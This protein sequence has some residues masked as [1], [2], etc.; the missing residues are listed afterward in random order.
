MTQPP[1]DHEP[2]GFAQPGFG[3]PPESNPP[4]P[5]Y[6]TAPDQPYPPQPYGTAPDQPYP[7]QPYG[8]V[9]PAYGY[10]PQNHGGATTAMWL[11][12]VSLAC[13]A[14]AMACCVTVPGVLTAPFAWVLG[15][16]A[17][18]QIDAEPGRYANRGQAVA[19]IVTGIIGTV[20]A[21]LIVLGVVAVAVYYGLNWDDTTS[22]GNA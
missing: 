10:G 7:P 21:I 11:G 6:G 2:D 9:P 17:K 15:V 19:G 14:L 8:Y 5:P 3:P 20:L 18:H 22:F 4:P 13:A 1:E 12:I 16:K